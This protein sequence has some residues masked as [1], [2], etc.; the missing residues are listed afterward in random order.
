MKYSDKVKPEHQKIID[1]RTD[2]IDEVN[3][4]TTPCPENS[5]R[6]TREELQFLMN[7]N[8]GEIDENFVKEGDDILKVFEDYCKEFDLEFDKKYYKKIIKESQK[9]VK[10]LKY[11]YN[12]PRPFQLAE[13]YNV[14]EFTSFELPS[15]KTPSYP[16]GHSTEG[17][18]LCLLL[19]KK[20]PTHYQE[21]KKLAD[22][23]SESRIMARAHYPSDCKFGEKVAMYIV[24]ELKDD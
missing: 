15:M 14:S 21:F 3:V 6:T 18:I 2:L 1:M 13:Y 10:K 22:F 9:T 11:E 17:N 7:F 23:I 24:G 8:N 12:R 16:S 20:Y 4:P 5:S 19:S